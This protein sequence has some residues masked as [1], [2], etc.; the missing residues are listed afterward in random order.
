MLDFRSLASSSAGC[1]YHL[2]GG[3][4]SR[5]ILIEAGIR[6]KLI[7]EGIGFRVSE[8]AGCL[9]SHAHGDH[10]QA[11]PNLVMHGV[12]VYTSTETADALIAKTK[13]FHSG[14]CRIKP[15]IEWKVGD[16]QVLPF[17]AIHD[18]PGTL[19]FVI[20]SPDGS[21]LLFLTDSAY[22]PYTFE[23]LTHIAIECNWSE[24]LI[25]DSVGSGS[26]NASRARRTV[27]THMSLERLV[28]MLKTNDLSRVEEI[29]LLHLSSQNSDAEGF[30]RTIERATGCPTFIADELSV[31]VSK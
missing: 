8:L 24:E 30:K 1:C 4:A 3:G 29:H 12:Q 10:A 18:A 17:E 26:I 21:R 23:K 7:Q 15:H 22:S 2:S 16:W 28:E 20:G 13:V 9:V 27:K 19:G 6:F 11:V 5:P 14:L 25:K 31:G